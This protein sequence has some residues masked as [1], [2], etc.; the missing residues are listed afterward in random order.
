VL[1]SGEW[2]QWRG[3][4][5]DGT[6]TDPAGWPD[7]LDH[8]ERLWR[9]ELGKGYPGPIVTADRVFVAETMGGDTEVVRA[10][11]RSSGRQIWE[12]SWL[13][14]GK[15]P[16]FAKSNGDWIRSTPAW[17]G[18]SLYV[19]GMNEVLVRLDGA[20][21]EV[22]WQVD[23]PARFGTD[24]PD[25]GFASSPLIDGDFVYVQAAN[26][27]IKLHRMTGDTVWRSLAASNG[28]KSSGAFSSPVLNE[29]HGARQLV[30]QTREAIHGLN[31][32]TGDVIWQHEVPAFRGMNI[33]TPTVYGDG[34]FT[35]TY[36][37]GSYFYALD[38]PTD[39]G[40]AALQVEE[41]WTSTGAGYMSSPVVVDGHV[42]LHLG[43]E[44]MTCI[45]LETGERRWTS[46]PIAKY[47][48]LAVREEKILLLT[49]DGELLLVR[50]NPERF[51]LMSRTSVSE[52][53]T[54]AH[55]AVAGDELFVRELEGISA[56]RWG[57][58][59]A[60]AA[61]APGESR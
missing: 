15:V 4:N 58:P 9:V 17:D 14:D 46:E 44:R 41:A 54:W 31:A 60:S 34:V 1:A 52:Q 5:R 24:I 20:T 10:L 25:F 45:D 43:N 37:N 18:E 57:S 48:S 26:S 6:V 29:I 11:E 55:L 51:E 3:P 7:D 56:Y 40:S 16:F 42:Y 32:E 33:L 22:V 50:A 8:L 23:F 53:Q 21:G 39:S 12:A 13:G 61:A 35:S 38:A 19:G 59:E 28:M 49:N 27:M 2:T 30:V 47:A 36:R